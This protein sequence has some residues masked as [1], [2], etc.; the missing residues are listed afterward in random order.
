MKNNVEELI[1]I[2]KSGVEITSSHD[3]EQFIENAITEANKVAT[4]FSYKDW[5]ILINM[6]PIERIKSH[7]Y[8]KIK[9]P[10][11]R[12]I[13]ENED[14]AIKLMINDGILKVII[15]NAPNDIKKLAIEKI[16]SIKND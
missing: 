14:S 10:S 2:I 1:K 7:D 12:S 6:L 9:G 4:N 5:E 3:D 15:K 13:I 8:N 16:K 11:I